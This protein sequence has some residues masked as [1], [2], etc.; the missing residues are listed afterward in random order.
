MT[1][2]PRSRWFSFLLFALLCATSLLAGGVVGARIGAG[3]ILDNWLTTRTNSTLS[4]LLIL[5]QMRN[6]DDEAAL[7]R[8]EA[9]LDR[10]IVSLLPDF[11]GGTRVSERAR[12][13]A[14]AALEQAREYRDEYP[15]PPAGRAI[16]RDV[17]RALS[18]GGA[19]PDVV[20]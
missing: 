12:A 4:H 9:Q 3:A 19:A 6:G 20:E 11:Y 1:G 10:D 16:D 8:L 5:R 14:A 2:T 15:R 13:R 17:Q 18:G 7:N